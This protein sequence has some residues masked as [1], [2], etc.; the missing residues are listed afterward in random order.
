MYLRDTKIMDSGRKDIRGKSN[1]SHL[2]AVCAEFFFNQILMRAKYAR[3]K[4]S[5]HI[6]RSL[7]GNV[8]I[9]KINYLY[10]KLFYYLLHYIHTYK[11]DFQNYY[12]AVKNRNRHAQF[13]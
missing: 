10:F 9:Q 8:F 11:F 12:T 3:K 7:F 1:Y 6:G 4:N 5:I 2:S 13:F